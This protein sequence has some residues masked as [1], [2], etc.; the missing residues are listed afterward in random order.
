LSGH[1]CGVGAFREGRKPN[2]K[3]I[4]ACEREINRGWTGDSG[5]YVRASTDG[6]I[7]SRLRAASE[8]R[9]ER[10]F[11]GSQIQL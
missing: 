11:T 5:F 2:L 8:A 4:A 1:D 6:A 9:S 7:C 10:D 3:M